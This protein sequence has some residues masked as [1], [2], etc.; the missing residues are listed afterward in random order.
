MLRCVTAPWTPLF[1]AREQLSGREQLAEE[2]LRIAKDAD[3]GRGKGVRVMEAAKRDVLRGPLADA[4]DGAQ[5]GDALFE[6]A[7]GFEEIRLGD[8]RAREGNEGGTARGGHAEGAEV[9]CGELLRRGKGV[10]EGCVAER[11]RR[12]R[13]R[14]ELRGKTTRGGDADLLAE[15]GADGDLEGLPAAGGTKAGLA[16]HEGGECAIAG[17]MRDDGLGVGVEVED[18]AQ[19]RCDEGQRGDVVT[20]DLNLKRIAGGQVADGDESYM[21]V[22]MAVN[23]DDAAVDA[24]A[25]LFD[26]RYRARDEE[27]EQRIPVEGRPI[28]EPQDQGSSSGGSDRAAAQLAGRTLVERAEGVIETADAAEAR[29]HG[30][31]QHR[32]ARFV[33]KLLGEEDAARLRD[34]QGGCADVLI[35][36]AT[37]LAFSHTERGGE[38]LDRGAGAIECTLCN[39]GHGAA[40]RAGS[41]APCGR[42]RRDLRTAAEAGAEAGVLGSGGRGKE[43]AVVAHGRARGADGAAIDAGGGDTGE[44]AA[45]EARIA[46]LERAIADF[47][48]EDGTERVGREREWMIAC[49]LHH[50]LSVRLWGAMCLAIFGRDG[51]HAPIV[52]DRGDQG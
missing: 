48:L 47:G 21:V 32:Q 35:E 8:G 37:E 23:P 20:G 46:G 44:E 19:A 50:L 31:G 33:E 5:A 43:A 28:G 6:R 49:V 12:C 9:G 41:A 11:E 24:V 34:G 26:A 18:A 22:C 30:Y 14:D 40:D 13:E 3:V 15:D 10:G 36:E 27:G 25:D 38:L 16:A 1:A 42:V 7:G 51:D 45:I 52:M 4:G 17:E 39:A 29:G 2:M